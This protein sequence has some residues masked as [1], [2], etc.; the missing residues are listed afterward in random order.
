[1]YKTLKSFREEHNLEIQHLS[2]MTNIDSEVISRLENTDFEQLSEL[3]SSDMKALDYLIGFMLDMTKRSALQER[4][5][6]VD[7]SQPDKGDFEVIPLNADGS[8]TDI[9]SEEAL[10]FLKSQFGSFEKQVDKRKAEAESEILKL[11]AQEIIIHQ[12][13]NGWVLSHPRLSPGLPSLKAEVRN[14]L[15]REMVAATPDDVLDSVY[16]W[17][18]GNTITQICKK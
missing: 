5:D 11:Q 16:K 10:E 2:D 1:M 13:G 7:H 12:T 6:S 4:S 3:S 15:N 18:Q 8:P 17:M 9:S 14:Q